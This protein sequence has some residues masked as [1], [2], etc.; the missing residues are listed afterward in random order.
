MKRKTILNA[1]VV[2][3]ALLLSGCDPKYPPEK[4]RIEKIYPLSVGEIVEVELIY[5][6][7]GGSMVIGWK[8]QKIKIITNNAVISVSG[9]TVTAIGKGTAT[10]E[11][12][13]TTVLT[14]ESYTSGN[15]DKVYKVV[16]KIYVK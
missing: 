15:S 10:I 1:C 5:P 11:I 3:I 7:D 13:A 4:L 9:L 14:D 8:D 6:Y 12:S 2:I 16:S